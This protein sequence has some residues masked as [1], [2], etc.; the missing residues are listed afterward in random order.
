[1][2]TKK[3][4]KCGA[5]IPIEMSFCLHCMERTDGVLEIKRKTAFNKKYIIFALAVFA[6][7]ITA[8]FFLVMGKSENEKADFSVLENP[9]S[10][11]TEVPK[12]ENLFEENKIPDIEERIKEKIL[13][14]ISEYQYSLDFKEN[15][16]RVIYYPRGISQLSFIAEYAEN[17]YT[18]TISEDWNRTT[19]Y[20]KEYYL[21]ELVNIFSSAILEYDIS[22]D[23]YENIENKFR[24]YYETDSVETFS[25]DNFICT[26][27]ISPENPYIIVK[28]ELT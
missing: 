9:V 21:P 24:E 2:Q 11:I 4:P 7:M 6:V 17:S 13:P 8:I 18:I 23:M 5:E 27:E 14:V 1:M 12:E 28:A 22:H 10:V 25:E 3:C 15:S 26:V 20:H 19:Y 16:C